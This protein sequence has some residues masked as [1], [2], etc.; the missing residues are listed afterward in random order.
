M[1]PEAQ[2]ACQFLPVPVRPTPALQVPSQ[3]EETMEVQQDN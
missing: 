3:A 1:A 2:C